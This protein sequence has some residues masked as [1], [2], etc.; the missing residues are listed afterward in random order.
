[1]KPPADAGGPVS[2]EA[3]AAAA[4]LSLEGLGAGSAQKIRAAF[5]SLAAA[6]RAGPE[7]VLARAEDLPPGAKESLQ[8]VTAGALEELGDRAMDAAKQAG[9]RVVAWGEP[10][11]PAMLMA[12]EGAPAL[13]WVRG[14]L[15]PAARRMAIV[16]ARKP[17][18]YGR[19]LARQIGEE[20]SRIGYEVVSGGA[21]G[22][23]EA[24]HT[25][26]LWAGGATVAVLG[27]GVDIAYP[28]EHEGLF[29][30]LASGGGALVSEFPPGTRPTGQNFPR[31]NRIIAGL[32]EG[33]VVTRAQLR[34][35]SLITADWA[36]R[37]GRKVFAVPG[38]VTDALSRGP[39]WLLRNGFAQAVQSGQDVEDRLSNRPI[40][41]RIPQSPR[42]ERA[43]G[44]DAP[45]EAHLV[46][47]ALDALEPRHFDAL[48]KAT[49]MELGKLARG[50]IE[51]QIRGLCEERPGKYFLRRG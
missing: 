9:A 48:L 42:S 2:A 32:S 45:Q 19:T 30:R 47:A 40:R 23:D 27:T 39:N 38:N 36:M 34:S 20:L 3:F 18:E 6:L 24:A 17:D 37:F 4:L 46:W 51:L 14:R 13:L 41:E 1:V 21:R 33:V 15:E 31:R 16:G 50:L 44:P 10:S 49:G 25:G 35:G 26:A 11:Y 7:E 29:E 28:R 8:N 12:V 5:G 43:P 22:V